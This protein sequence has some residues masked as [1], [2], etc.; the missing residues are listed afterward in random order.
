MAEAIIAAP[1]IAIID[2]IDSGACSI[3]ISTRAT[4]RRRAKIGTA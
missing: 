1:R 3:A 2:F 4:I